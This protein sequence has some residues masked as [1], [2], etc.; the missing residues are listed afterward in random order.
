MSN[1]DKVHRKQR[2][3]GMA[4]LI[5]DLNNASSIAT[6]SVKGVPAAGSPQVLQSSLMRILG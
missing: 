5:A 1:N 4:S 6:V 3:Q 2:L